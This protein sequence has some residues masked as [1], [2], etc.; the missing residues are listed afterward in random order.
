MLPGEF[1]TVDGVKLHL[2]RKGEGAPCVVISTGGG[3]AADRWAPLVDAIAEFTTV[4]VYDRP[5]YGW[6]EPSRVPRTL[7]NVSRELEGLLD[8]AALRGPFVLVGHSLG[9][10]YVR[11]FARRNP[12]Q[13]AGIVLVDSSHEQQ[14]SRLPRRVVMFQKLLV[15]VLSRRWVLWLLGPLLRRAVA[16]SLPATA[17]SSEESREDLL[18]RESSPTKVIATMAEMDA[19]GDFGASMATPLP[20]VPMVVLVAGSMKAPGSKGAEDAALRRTWLELQ[21]ELTAM[22]PRGEMRIV[23]G[24]GHMIPDDK[25]EAVIDAVRSLVMATR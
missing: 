12:D 3:V 24:A 21:R 10:P 6:S 20:P 13:V 17:G 18:Q 25:P 9:G 22:S 1:H 7:D 15:L 2:I 19:M 11:Q 14:L 8:A 23:E 16:R 4:A 5:G